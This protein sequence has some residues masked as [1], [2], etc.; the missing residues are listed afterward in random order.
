MPDAYSNAAILVV[1]DDPGI[2]ELLAG[3]LGQAGYR[4]RAVA[5]GEGMWRALSEDRF[6]AVVLDLMLPGV[7]GIA[8]CRQ[9]R[10][11]SS[12]PVIMLTARGQA[13]D[14]IV[15]LESGADDYMA[16]PF[17][18][19]ELLARLRSVL[20]RSLGAAPS[21]VDIASQARLGFADWKVDVAAHELQAPDGRVIS[22]GNSDFRMLLVLLQ[23]AGQVLD[24][25]FLAGQ[26]YGRDRMPSDRTI[27]MCVSRLRQYLEDDARHP[28]LIRTVRNQGYQ[29]TA[30]V[31]SDG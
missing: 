28:T 12:L 7:D 15:G 24:R 3:Y 14:R 5:D 25:D 21:A 11:Q 18:P 2:G 23:H 8:L 27:D 26:V 4:T 30:R 9:L 22:L 17:D 6:D 13:H 31:R 19:R 29:F 10:L 1:D 20:R 16:K